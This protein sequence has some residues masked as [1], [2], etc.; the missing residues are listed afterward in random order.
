[1][2]RDLLHGLAGTLRAD[3]I[4]DI[5]GDQIRL[6]FRAMLFG[7]GKEKRR[8]EWPATWWQ[9]FKQ[10]WFPRWALRR[11]PVKMEVR[12]WEVFQRVCP[13]LNVPESDRHVRWMIGDDRDL[14]K[15]PGK[16]GPVMP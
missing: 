10:R 13:H 1:M 4:P 12:E 14:A 16:N 3:A 11:W 7:N 15:W 9:H 2:S 6:M 5:M 8:C